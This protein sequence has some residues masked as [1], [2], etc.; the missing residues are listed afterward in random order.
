MYGYFVVG[1][2]FQKSCASKFVRSAG[3][4]GQVK[5]FA[6][7]A[8]VRLSYEAVDDEEYPVRVKYTFNRP[9]QKGIPHKFVVWV[10]FNAEDRVVLVVF[11]DVI[12]LAHAFERLPDF[13]WRSQIILQRV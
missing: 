11:V 13:L 12:F 6:V 8:H 5:R 10:S 9:Q 1:A 4:E 3:D 7:K 2:P